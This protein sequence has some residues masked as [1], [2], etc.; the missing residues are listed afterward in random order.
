[1]DFNNYITFVPA[2]PWNRLSHS[3]RTSKPSILSAT[4]HVSH[5]SIKCNLTPSKNPPQ[6]DAPAASFSSKQTLKSSRRSFIQKVSAAVIALPLVQVP[7][8]PV[9]AGKEA[10]QKNGHRVFVD[11]SIV[12]KP[13]GRITIDLF[14]NEAPGSVDTFENLIS[15]TLRNRKGRIAGYRYSQATQVI[16]HSRVYLGRLNQIDSLNQASGTPQRQQV[17]VEAP[18]N[19]DKND[20]LHDRPGLVSVEKGGGFEFVI[21]AKP[22]PA[23]DETNIVI[24]EVV[25]GM[26]LVNTLV[27]VPI[28]RKT[29]R[30]GYRS[31]GKAIGDPRAKVQVELS[32]Q[33]TPNH[34]PN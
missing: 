5:L 21:T 34:T 23:L 22:D 14:P 33:S 29:I 24:G 11:I 16:P 7:N 8:V 10:P 19:N 20:L 13:K 12:G 9:E 28:N 1:M 2:G 31:V 27:N 18:L 32:Y 15:G 26:D 6:V 30:D 25:D 4:R 3:L 17:V